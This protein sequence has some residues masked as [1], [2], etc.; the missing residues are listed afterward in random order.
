MVRIAHVRCVMARVEDACLSIEERYSLSVEDQQWLRDQLNLPLTPKDFRDIEAGLNA[1]RA[2]WDAR[3][4]APNHEDVEAGLKRIEDRARELS[5]L[6]DFE[7]ADTDTE[8][9]DQVTHR[10]WRALR[11][12]ADEAGWDRD[13][14]RRLAQELVWLATAAEAAREDV[15]ERRSVARG[16]YTGHLVPLFDYLERVFQR[17]GLRISYTTNSIKDERQSPLAEAVFEIG[18][19]F[20][21]EDAQPSSPAAVIR[22]HVE[23]KRERKRRSAE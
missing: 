19:R 16:P 17:H 21:P 7:R 22:Q 12:R 14:Y 18:T 3:Q 2:K 4:N 5:G 20:L 6:V 8:P 9:A 23:L 1:A 15:A 10:V 11:R 13:S